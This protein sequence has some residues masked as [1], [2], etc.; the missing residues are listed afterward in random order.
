MKMYADS[1]HFVKLKKVRRQHTKYRKKEE[2]T[3]I[4][5]KRRK[6]SI[7]IANKQIGRKQGAGAG[8][9]RRLQ[10]GLVVKAK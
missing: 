9:N 6:N 2:C 8:K 4:A 3:P 1:V 10:M 5:Y 7:K